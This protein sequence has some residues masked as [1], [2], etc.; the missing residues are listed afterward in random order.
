MCL[1]LSSL[2]EISKLFI[3]VIAFVGIYIAWQQFITNREKVKLDLYD[4]R[5]QLYQTIKECV[6]EFIYGEEKIDSE[7]LHS[8]LS[9]CSEAQFLVPDDLYEKIKEVERLV[10]KLMLNRKRIMK[11]NTDELA[12]TMSDLESELERLFPKFTESFKT[13]IKFNKF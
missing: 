7:R 3:P 8:F 9:A 1:N 12:S 2:I 4:K 6:F 10:N 11:N 13:V 5:F